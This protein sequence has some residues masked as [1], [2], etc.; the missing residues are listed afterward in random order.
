MDGTIRPFG[1]CTSYRPVCR[2]RMR[3]RERKVSFL[4]NSS[5]FQTLPTIVAGS[6]F[7]QYRNRPVR[8]FVT[9]STVYL[10]TDIAEEKNIRNMAS[11]RAGSLISA[12]PS[13]PI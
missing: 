6:S 7:S 1:D 8:S 5:L 12:I 11:I 13:R 4:A 2:M 9:L 10:G 3:E